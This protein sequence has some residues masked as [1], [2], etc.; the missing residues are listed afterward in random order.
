MASVMARV[1]TICASKTPVI[2][3]HASAATEP[4]RR[5][6]GAA[7]ARGVVPLQTSRGEV[8]ASHRQVPTGRGEAS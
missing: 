2:V 3:P 6:N 1:M 4:A 7:A 8:V 5:K